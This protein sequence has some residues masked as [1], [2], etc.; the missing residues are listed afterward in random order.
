MA[1][2]DPGFPAVADLYPQ[3]GSDHTWTGEDINNRLPRLP[4][5]KNKF[6]RFAHIPVP[7]IMKVGHQNCFP[8]AAARIALG[9]S[10][11]RPSS[12]HLYS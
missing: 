11:E 6:Q 7:F 12:S 3:K 4:K 10:M 8:G 9:W 5:Y 2:G 1:P